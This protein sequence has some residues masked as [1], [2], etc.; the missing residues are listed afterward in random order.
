MLEIERIKVKKLTANPGKSKTRYC[1][2]CSANLASRK[3]LEKE[4]STLISQFKDFSEKMSVLR[5]DSQRD[6]LEP[7]LMSGLQDDPNRRRHV[8]MI[9][10]FSVF[11]TKEG[12]ISEY[13]LD[14]KMGNEFEGEILYSKKEKNDIEMQASKLVFPSGMAIKKYGSSKAK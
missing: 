8:G 11:G 2:L 12:T 3:D 5:F 13:M 4:D 6:N 10:N 14:S 7:S 1:S 9:E